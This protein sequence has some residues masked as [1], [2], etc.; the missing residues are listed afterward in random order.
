LFA[1]LAS[2]LATHT[3]HVLWTLIGVS[4]ARD[5][6]GIGCWTA[7][8]R[9]PRVVAL[10]AQPSASSRA[11]PRRSARWRRPARETTYS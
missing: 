7:E 1:A 10:V 4:G 11:T 5:E 2:A 8:R 3:A 9:P 6:I